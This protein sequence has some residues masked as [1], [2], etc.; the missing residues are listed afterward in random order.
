MKYDHVVNKILDHYKKHAKGF[1]SFSTN[2]DDFKT[3]SKVELETMAQF[4]LD[5]GIAEVDPLKS[6]NISLIELDQKAPLPEKQTAQ[7]TEPSAQEFEVD[8]PSSTCQECN[9]P[10]IMSWGKYNY[11]LHCDNCNKN[12][13]INIKCPNCKNK[14]KLSKNKNEYRLYCESCGATGYHTF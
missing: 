9:K 11:Y 1:W 5:N 7:I 12:V 10:M 4:I 14:L 3:L 13:P 6:F 8:A 2:D